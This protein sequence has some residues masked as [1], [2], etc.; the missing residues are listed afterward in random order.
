M[1]RHPT[2]ATGRGFTVG[3]GG[4][5]QAPARPTPDAVSRAL[6]LADRI[7]ASQNQ[8]HPLEKRRGARRLRIGTSLQPRLQAVV[9]RATGQ[10][11]QATNSGESGPNKRISGDTVGD[12]VRDV[13]GPAINPLIKIP[14]VV[15]LLS[16]PFFRENSCLFLPHKRGRQRA[17]S[18]TTGS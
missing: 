3:A 11:V 5:I 17:E 10:L 13:T 16:R 1:D 9:R 7:T 15:V 12:A 8:R 18:D 2:G 4:T 14:I 6:A